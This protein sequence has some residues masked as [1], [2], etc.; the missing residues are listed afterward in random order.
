[1]A[2][3]R[4]DCTYFGARRN[5]IYSSFSGRPETARGVTEAPPIGEVVLTSGYGFPPPALT[6][7]YGFSRSPL[8]SGYGFSRSPLTSGYGFPLPAHSQNSDRP[9]RYYHSRRRGPNSQ[10]PANRTSFPGSQPFRRQNRQGRANFGHQFD[11]R[12]H[13]GRSHHSHSLWQPGMRTAGQMSARRGRVTGGDRRFMLHGSF[14]QLPLNFDPWPRGPTIP[15]PNVQTTQ[16]VHGPGQPSFEVPP[17]APDTNLLGQI[18]IPR[19][20]RSSL[21]STL[22]HRSSSGSSSDATIRPSSPLSDKTITMESHSAARA[23]PLV[24]DGRSDW[25]KRMENLKITDRTS[26]SAGPSAVTTT[27]VADNISS[28]EPAADAYGGDSES[29][30]HYEIAEL[31]AEALER[32]PRGS[33]IRRTKSDSQLPTLIAEEDALYE[34]DVSSSSKASTSGAQ[35]QPVL[36]TNGEETPTTPTPASIVAASPHLQPSTSH[37]QQAQVPDLTM[38]N[39]QI[40]GGESTMG[41]PQA[42]VFEPIMDNQQIHGGESTMGNPQ[43]QVFEP[44]MENHYTQQGASSGIG[45]PINQVYDP[46]P[47]PN[48][49]GDMYQMPSYGQYPSVGLPVGHPHPGNSSFMPPTPYGPPLEPGLP[50]Q[51][52]YGPFEPAMHHA[53]IPPDMIPHNHAH[54]WAH[55]QE[56]N[57]HYQPPSY[58]VQNANIGVSGPPGSGYNQPYQYLPPMHPHP[59][60]LPQR[61]PCHVEG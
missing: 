20:R 22:C 10:L 47:Y 26:T 6:S 34:A 28:A 13:S 21:D 54:D 36:P 3:L 46:S 25:G 27:Q 15:L 29:E 56:R 55:H 44:I 37:N 61:N 30:Y 24:V 57:F 35:S 41:N 16:A 31:F 60:M 19:S 11:G 38:D 48:P 43:A 32:P 17:P 14:Q 40:H 59:M 12:G 2:G 1:M 39:Q 33:R 53:G 4:Q 23:R 7:G 8:T 5:N 9:V 18:I 51:T 58:P 50:I 42:Q 45:M 49:P 52:G